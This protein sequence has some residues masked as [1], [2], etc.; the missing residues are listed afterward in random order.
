MKRWLPLVALAAAQFLMVLDQSVMNVSISQLVEDFDTSVTTIQAVIT[1]YCLV[2]AMFMLTGG[3]IGDIIGRR[4]AFT[5][6]LIIYGCGS[7]LTAAAPTVEI[8]ALGWSI[9]EG[10]GAALVLP[11]LAALIAGNYD[12][13]ERKVAYAVIGGVAGAGIAIGPILGGWA[14]TELTWRVVFL[15]EVAVVIFIL[16]MT[17]RVG[18]AIRSGPKP[19]LDG[20]GTVLS[21]SGLGLFV[22]GVLQS[23][24]WGWVEPK[25][26]PIEPLGFSLTLFV[27][28]AGAALLW[29]FVR[30]QRHREAIGSDPLVHLDLLRIPPLRSGLIGMLSQNLILMGVFFALP[31][32]L[33]L[34]LGLDALETGV[35]MLPISIAMFATSAIGSRLSLRFSVR[36]VVRA[37]LLTT[38]L[39]IIALIATI[40][41]ELDDVPFAISMGLLGVGMGLIVSQLG[42]VV[43]SSVDASGR[44][45]AGGL[46]Y[47]GQQLGSSLGVALIGAIVLSG[48][49]GAFISNIEDDARIADEITAP[50]TA[51]VEDSGIDFIDSDQVAAA[52]QDAGLDDATAQAI[53]DDY[54]QAQLQALNAGLLVAGFLALDLA[55]VHRRPAPRGTAVQA[56]HAGQRGGRDLTAGA[57]EELAPEE[58]HQGDHRELTDPIAVPWQADVGRG[59]V[60]TEGHPEPDGAYR[61]AL[62]LGRSGH[63]GGRQPDVGPQQPSHALGHRHRRGLGDDRALRHPEQVELHLAVVG[64]HAPLEP[65][66]RSRHVHDPGRHQAAGERL[67]DGQR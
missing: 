5:I 36:A 43:Q 6:G 55:R 7:G 17:P 29:G 10:L 47:T 32:Y 22:L 64:D 18:D 1:L 37:G 14:T 62:L 19:H 31:L 51:A 59:H 35:K 49:A 24:T 33:Q 2:M 25:D 58:V 40:E 9:L 30:W 23:T 53:V 8:L 56:G 27:I 54:E 63:A 50:L 26:S 42:N 41:P 60:V 38:L 39:S 57:A 16:A 11:A 67:G 4:R 45:E 66:A 61:L 65:L 12:G 28:A 15:G 20:M 48:L 46:Q 52:A 13:H 3:K 34:V 21:A 44:G